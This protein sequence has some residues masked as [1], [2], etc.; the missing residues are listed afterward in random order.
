MA[1]K[2]ER[3]NEA[4]REARP[5]KA[6]LQNE[7]TASPRV[8]HNDAQRVDHHK[9]STY[10]LEPGGSRKSTRGSTDRAKPDS[11]QQLT[12]RRKTTSPAARNARGV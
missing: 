9:K 10:L 7:V 8:S 11:A 5:K 2:A 4:A 6:T 3:F 12:A 1:T